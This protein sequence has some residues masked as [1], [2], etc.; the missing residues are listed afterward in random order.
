MPRTT[1]SPPST[2]EESS[3]T[4]DTL[5]K[6]MTTLIIDKV[7]GVL[8]SLFDEHKPIQYIQKDTH[9]KF[10]VILIEEASQ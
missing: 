9:R 8:I 2:T 10:K 3:S 7:M 4:V 1:T 6:T 5:K